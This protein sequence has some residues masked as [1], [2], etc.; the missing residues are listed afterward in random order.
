MAF[1]TSKSGDN[2]LDQVDDG[3]YEAEVT[4]FQEVENKFKGQLFNPNKEEGEDNRRNPYETQYEF[5]FT[6]TSEGVTS[7]V[8]A[9][10]TTGERSKLRKIAKALGAWEAREMNGEVVEG[11]DD[12]REN[13]VGRQ[14]RVLVEGGRISNFLRA[15]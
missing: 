14:C 8:W 15:K 6:L 2:P 1:V 7:K 9:N 13:M 10:P 4:E 3:M 5:D 12:S 11:F